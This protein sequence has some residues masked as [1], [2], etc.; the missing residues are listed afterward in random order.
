MQKTEPSLFQENLTALSSRW[1]WIADQVTTAS[2]S[3][4]LVSRDDGYVTVH[5]TRDGGDYVISDHSNIA[6]DLYTFRTEIKK[7]LQS[8]VKLYFLLGIGLGERL[9][10]LWHELHSASRGLV[11]VLEESPALLRAACE[12]ADLRPVFASPRCELIVDPHLESHAIQVIQEQSWFG[13][14]QSLFFWGY[15]AHDHALQPPYRQ[16]A[17]SLTEH[18][19]RLQQSFL[20]DWQDWV[21]RPAWNPRK[22]ALIY[23]AGSGNDAR[24]QTRNQLADAD[25]VEIAIPTGGFISPTWLRQQIVQSRMDVLVWYNTTPQAWL[26]AEEIAQI[27]PRIKLLD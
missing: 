15:Q 14:G 11:V 24:Q 2:R 22:I 21:Q 4:H 26:P 13:V 16:L 27:G 7:S 5:C 19:K 6:A 23:L 9:C 1:P 20:R 8:G 12:C 3:V 17:Q 10:A 18:I 25:I